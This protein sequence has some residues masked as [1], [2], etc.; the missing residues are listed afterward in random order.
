M[1]TTIRGAYLYGI[2]TGFFL[3]LAVMAAAAADYY[4]ST[5]FVGSAFVVFILMIITR[6]P[7]RV[8]T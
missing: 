3:G 4:W 8:N 5:Y 6:K 7:P 2:A 1:R